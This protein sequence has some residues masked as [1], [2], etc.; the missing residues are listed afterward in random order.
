[1][2]DD[3]NEYNLEEDYL[4]DDNQNKNYIKKEDLK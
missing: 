4:K 2:E 3:L 1:M